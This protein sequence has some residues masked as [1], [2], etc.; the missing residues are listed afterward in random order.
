MR[1]GVDL[2]VDPSARYS[3]LGLVGNDADGA[4]LARCAV[5]SA[6]RAGEALDPGDV[7]D[8]DV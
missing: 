6:L 5:Q 3:K 2:T 1:D 4:R 8:V 7:V